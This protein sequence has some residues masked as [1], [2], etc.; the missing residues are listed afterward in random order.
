MVGI[1]GILNGQGENSLGFK[2]N[3]FFNGNPLGNQTQDQSG[4]ANGL[5]NSVGQSL[6]QRLGLNLPTNTTPANS[7]AN[8]L[9]NLVKT[10]KNNKLEEI[11]KESEKKKD[12]LETSDEE[13]TD[14]TQN[15]MT[16]LKNGA[17]QQVVVS[18]DGRF[19][20]SI[21][22][23][24]NADGSYTL[25]MS[26]HF[27][28]AQAAM[29]SSAQN[30]AENQTVPTDVEGQ[31]DESQ[32]D[33]N[34]NLEEDPTSLAYKGAGAA[35]QRY[36]SYEQV[37]QARGFEANIFFEEAKSVAY[38]AEQAYG[39]EMGNKYMAVAGELSHEYTLNI[40]ISGDDLSNF[41]Q[42]AE[43]L[44]QFD[45]SGTLGG[46]L[47]AA[48]NVL[49]TDS[50]NLGAFVE[51]TQSLVGATQEHVSAK[52]TNFFSSMQEQFGGTLEELGFEP[53]FIE[54]LGQDVQSDLNNFFQI[55]NAMLGSLMDTEQV[56]EAED[57]DTQQLESLSAQ[58]EEMKE[59]RRDL[60]GNEPLPP[61]PE[62]QPVF[63]ND[64]PPR[65]EKGFVNAIA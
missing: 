45:D 36:T 64:L 10:D 60:L 55:T 50:S 49:N 33:Q 41:N 65:P 52:L 59:K 44:M 31:A 48:R 13:R 30:A 18:K 53:N 62:R 35:Y 34:A 20:A 63:Q 16:A 40:S 7:L 51:A 32:E 57:T 28:N 6:S 58:L 14:A 54:N 37:L 29:M 23:R 5:M 27:A 3:G 21:D 46:F 61:R 4:Q 11:R 1:L 2:L 12:R 38:A 26:V 8:Q 43:E 15:L 19:E 42:V 56:E 22:M 25:D 9:N 24:L 47:E 39:S 17:T